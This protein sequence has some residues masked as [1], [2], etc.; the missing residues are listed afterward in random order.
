MQIDIT[1]ELN[2]DGKGVI[3]LVLP[4]NKAWDTAEA[5]KGFLTIAGHNVRQ[6]N[7]DGEELVSA[8]EVFPDASPAKALRGLR[9][10][11]ELTQEEFAAQ[12]GIAQTMVSEMETGKRAISRAMAKRIGEAF[13]ISHKVFL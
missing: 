11:E 8:A 10:R 9:T 2:A 13:C 1:H 3:S 4:A 12:L 6:I 7:G 5:I